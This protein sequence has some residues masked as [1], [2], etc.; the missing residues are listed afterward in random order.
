[1]MF[2][3]LRLLQESEPG[4]NTY[5]QCTVHYRAWKQDLSAWFI[6]LVPVKRRN[7]H[8]RNYT[9]VTRTAVN[10]ASS[11][12]ELGLAMDY[13]ENWATLRTVEGAACYIGL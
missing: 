13:K 8:P 5:E 3:H 1:M 7:K 11:E 9:E 4:K 6:V 2:Q 10:H 12:R